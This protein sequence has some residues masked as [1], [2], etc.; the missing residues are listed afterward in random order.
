MNTDV[1][2]DTEI[3]TLQDWT[4]V[5]ACEGLNHKRGLNG[6]II[7]QD[8]TWNVISPCCGPKV[9]QCDGRVQ[10]MREGGLLYCGMCG[11]E[12]LVEAYTF[13]LIGDS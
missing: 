3:F 6:H 12:H 10:N 9:I 2:E 11:V 13:V 1:I 8:G 7:E 5:I 4:P